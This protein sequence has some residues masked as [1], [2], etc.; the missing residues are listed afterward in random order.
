MSIKSIIELRNQA[1]EII[2][3]TGRAKNTGKRVGGSILDAIDTFAQADIDINALITALQDQA[4]ETLRAGSMAELRAN[5]DVEAWYLGGTTYFGG[6]PIIKRVIAGSLFDGI[7]IIPRSAFRTQILIGPTILNDDDSFNTSTSYHSSTIS[8]YVNGQAGYTTW[9]YDSKGNEDIRSIVLSLQ[10][11]NAL[12]PYM[13]PFADIVDSGTIQG[14]SI[15]GGTG[16][17]VFIKNANFN[18][19]IRPM[20][21]LRVSSGGGIGTVT[22]Y[23]NWKDVGDYP[24]RDNYDNGTG[25]P[26]SDRF[27]I[28]RSNNL[29]YDW[30]GED[31]L[32]IVSNPMRNNLSFPELKVIPRRRNILSGGGASAGTNDE[33]F[34]EYSLS[35]EFTAEEKTLNPTL[36]LARVKFTGC[37]FGG[38]DNATTS[39]KKAVLSEALSKEDAH[40]NNRVSKLDFRLEES[41][42][43]K[44]TVCDRLS[45][46]AAK[47]GNGLTFKEI[48]G[49]YAYFEAIGGNALLFL[50]GS[51]S[52]KKRSINMTTGQGEKVLRM[53][54]V[55][56]LRYD[57]PLYDKVAAAERKFPAYWFKTPRYIYG[58]EV[59]LVACITQKEDKDVVYS[60]S[61]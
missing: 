41:L 46:K 35:R 27:Y 42:S 51:R 14:Q 52:R 53:P 33:S 10:A 17:V 3:E 49:R 21:A 7:L 48:V 50:S 31:L 19:D 8:R 40:Y 55:M 20:F 6:K 13:L 2:N 11:D 45:F 1:I 30:N 24:D 34:L 12:K 36:E 23:G 32:P 15:S 54:L 9:Q 47:K 5:L 60:I 44:S 39:S 56:R 26:Q 16:D 38:E 22:Y 61:K 43:D 29:K 4:I 37:S 18:L 58:A 59:K 57:N 28:N 25:N